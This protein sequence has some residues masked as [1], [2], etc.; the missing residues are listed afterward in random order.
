MSWPREQS[1]VPAEF[2]QAV[3]S[4][5]GAVVRDEVQVADMRPPQ[6]LAPWSHAV[7]LDVRHG[8]VEIAAGRLVLL[9][10]PAG[11][12]AWNGMMRLVGY[13]SAELDPRSE[14]HTSE[15]QS[16]RHLVCRLLL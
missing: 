4:L 14:E 13:G 2:A 8:G 7:S 6:Q 15:L 1:A 12:D 16:L 3:R 9:Y 10:D 5:R 11:Y